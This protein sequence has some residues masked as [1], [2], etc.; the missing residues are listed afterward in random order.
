MLVVYAPLVLRR[1]LAGGGLVWLWVVFTA[2]FM[3]ARFVVLVRRARGDRW[4][5]TGT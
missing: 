3:G 4:L 1:A 2:V 5:V